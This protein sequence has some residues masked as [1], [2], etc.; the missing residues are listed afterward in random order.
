MPT[1]ILD[2]DVAAK[3]AAGEVVE[4]PVS[5]VKELVDNS[6]DAGAT[7][8]SIEI[9]G[10][11]LNLIRIA[12][13]GTGLAADEVEIAFA[14]HATSKVTTTADLE[15]IATL[16]FRGEALPS[17]AAVAR[18]S[19]ETCSEKETAGAKI[20]IDNGIVI[21]KKQFG[22]P[23][24][25]VIQVETLFRKVPARLKFLKST[26]AENGRISSLLILY[27]LAY[28]EVKF[29]LTIEGKTTL[30]TP[31]SGV[32]LDAIAEVYGLDVTDNMVSLSTDD[33]GIEGST[34]RVDGYTSNP[35]LTRSNRSYINLF[36]NRRLIKN[37][38]LTYALE[39]AYRGLI[40]T[41]R[42]PIAI[43]NIYMP[44]DEVD[45]NVHPAKTEVRF[46]DERAVFAAVQRAARSALMGTV[47]TPSIR[48][49]IMHEQSLPLP[50]I[51]HPVY[52]PAL[53]ESNTAAIS[54]SASDVDGGV[55]QSTLPML[56]VVGQIANTYIICEG[57][58]GMYLIDQHAAHE[59]IMYER[60]RLE[61]EQ[62]TVGVQGLL[63]LTTVELSP[64]QELLLKSRSEYLIGYGFNIE[65]FGDR[66]YVIRSVPALIAGRNLV[67]SVLSVIDSLGDTLADMDDQIAVS[68]ACH[69]AIKAGQLLGSEEI[70]E[71][72]GQ[73]EK[74]ALPYNC[75]HGRPTIIKITTDQ[76]EK[77]F[78]R[79]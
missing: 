58:D 25:T 3:I 7:V 47:S 44:Y 28:P 62:R 36:V 23:K 73:L 30:R 31:G 37:Q 43:V 78:K 17:I 52:H 76:L 2:A 53:F 9:K 27:A 14:R 32:L 61:R 72:I 13:D 46:K 67:D 48:H 69:G 70:R 11:G 42:H 51:T 5:V 60:I 38:S 41:G 18:V 26:Q 63:E 75:P 35:S 15:I 4:R 68:M 74:A 34:I 6:L 29:T 1:R 39:E 57:P 65:P 19:M 20:I 56:R 77:D 64:T 55:D 59:R 40:V 33:G 49:N 8:I 50:H 54:K 79:K 16:G 12:D 45:V 24:G 10:G 22:C 21:E 71:L 66:T